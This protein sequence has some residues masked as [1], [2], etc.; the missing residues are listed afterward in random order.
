MNGLTSFQNQKNLASP[1]KA[2]PRKNILI[3]ATEVLAT[4]GV[5]SEKVFLK[6]SQNSQENTCARVSFLM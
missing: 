1:Q 2:R 5:L 6:I 4:G 3:N